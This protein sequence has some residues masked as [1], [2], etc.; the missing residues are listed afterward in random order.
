M[1]STAVVSVIVR[2]AP[3]A[4]PVT[5]EQVTT[6]PAMAHAHPSPVAASGRRPSGTGSTTVS[7]PGSS[8]GPA[9]VTVRV[10]VASVPTVRSPVCDLS[11]ARSTSGGTATVSVEVLSVR[12]GSGV[13]E[14]TVAVLATEG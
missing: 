2:V 12:S 1:G 5:D 7:G 11:R 10:H 8:V 6:W 13:V 14:V 4:R 9:L 3:T